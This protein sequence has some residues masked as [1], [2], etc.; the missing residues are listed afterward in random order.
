MRTWF[1]EAGSIAAR[2]DWT[3][4]AR[5]L[6]KTRLPIA[7]VPQAPATPTRCPLT[8]RCRDTPCCAPQ[9][10]STGEVVGAATSTWLTFNLKTRKMAR[11]PA[12]KRDAVM[13][14]SSPSPPRWALDQ[15]FAPD[16]VGDIAHAAPLAGSSAH[17]ICRGDMDMNQHVNNVAYLKW[18]TEDVP[19]EVFKSHVLTGVDLEY[20]AEGHYGET[21][22]GPL[23]R[24]ACETPGA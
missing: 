16:K 17:H 1:Q 3:F 6:G 18:V 10:L 12:E 23:P 19:M 20:R 7:P 11:L 21:A 4:E 24:H 9:N 22:P 5:A 8:T 13:R 2:R 14:S 15:G